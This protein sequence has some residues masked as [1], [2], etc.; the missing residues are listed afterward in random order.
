[1]ATEQSNFLNLKVHL[2]ELA[3][4]YL[5]SLIFAAHLSDFFA[6]LLFIILACLLG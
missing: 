2:D 5:I 1:M 3:H 4:I 6:F